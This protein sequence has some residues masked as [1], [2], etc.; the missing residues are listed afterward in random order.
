MFTNKGRAAKF[1]FVHYILINTITSPVVLMMSDNFELQ[2]SESENED[3]ELK[4]G[5]YKSF[6]DL[7][8][9]GLYVLRIDLIYLYR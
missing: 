5:F 1:Q 8:T 9:F 2:L 4:V 6:V 3:F 7:F